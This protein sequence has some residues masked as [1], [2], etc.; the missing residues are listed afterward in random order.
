MLVRTGSGAGLAAGGLVIETPPLEGGG[1]S[2]PCECVQF[3]LAVREQVRPPGGAPDPP[4][5]LERV[6]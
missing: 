5:S 6:F 1:Q 4:V 3:V 2:P